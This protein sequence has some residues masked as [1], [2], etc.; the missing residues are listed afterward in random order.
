MPSPLRTPWVSSRIGLQLLCSQRLQSFGFLRQ[1]SQG[2]TLVEVLV[3]MLVAVIFVSMTMQALVT[4]A[5]FRIAATQYD[6]A[7]SWI[8]E[9]LEAVVRQAAQ[10]ETTALP[11]SSLCAAQ[12][13]ANGLAASFI[14]D[15][16]GG[17]GGSSAT[18]GPRALGGK[19]YN[20]TRTA[21]YTDS[22]DPFKVL[23]VT[24]TVIPQ[25][26]TRPIANVRTEVIPHGVF[27]CP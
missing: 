23:Y 19:Y 14:N 27:K 20:M 8:Q 18:L 1:S 17:L 13:S 25:G 15:S 3:S 24:Y 16:T 4:S 2:F 21:T 12:T 11:Y 6:E 26:E 5:M 22:Y 9:D 10:Y 7:V